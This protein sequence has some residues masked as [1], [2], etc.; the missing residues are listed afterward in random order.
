MRAHIGKLVKQRCSDRAIKMAVIPGGLTPYLQAGDVG[1][2]KLFKDNISML[3]EWKR[4]D[5][6]S[7]TQAGNPRAPDIS[8][9]APWV[10]QAWKETPL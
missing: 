9:V 10:L 8:Q 2:Y 4:S 1:I 3:N 7:Y 5:K 6:V